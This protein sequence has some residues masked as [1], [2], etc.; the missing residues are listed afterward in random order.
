MTN[1]SNKAHS[2]KSIKLGPEKLKT[3]FVK[4]LNRIYY[5]KAHLVAKLPLLLD[6]VYF[7]DL[8]QA[9]TETVA[10]VEKQ[11]ARMELIYELLDSEISK[12]SIHG[13]TGLVDDAFEAIREQD[14][15]AELRDM[16]I[17]F[18][19][20]NIESVEMA[21]FQVLEMAA[22]KI[23]NKQIKH[24]LKENYDEAK[25]DRTLLLL[26]GAKYVSS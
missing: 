13:L 15:E 12:G 26:I 7:K 2:P 5:A 22:V 23:K 9:I 21:S 1:P 6:E 25:A 11:M 18:Y 24:L 4:H 20:Q 14:G 10:D 17:I 3:F 16:S 8:Q 19:L